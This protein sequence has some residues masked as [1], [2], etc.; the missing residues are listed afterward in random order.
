MTFE[1]QY[2]DSAKQDRPKLQKTIKEQIKRA[3][4]KKLTTFPEIFGKPLRN[5]LQG[6]RR[7][8]VGD[9][10]VIFRIEKNIVKIFK[11]EHRS[12]VYRD[13][14]LKIIED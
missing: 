2:A 7:I 4:E 14:I 6:Y 1:I 12:I 10:R 8:R 11:I 3:I 5:S 9:Y 13:L